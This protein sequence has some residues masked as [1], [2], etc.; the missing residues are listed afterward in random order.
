MMSGTILN[1]Q[2]RPCSGRITQHRQQPV[3]PVVASYSKQPAAVL[4]A[5]CPV[6]AP[7]RAA[8]LRHSLS[9][10]TRPR[11]RSGAAGFS[12]RA[13]QSYVMIKPDGVQ[14][15][16]V[17]RPSPLQRFLRPTR[18]RLGCCQRTVRRIC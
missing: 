6:H 5:S 18:C 15:G 14:R 17:R 16:L 10:A 11:S 13:E 4:H 12:V 9:R 7:F 1:Q 3:S 8:T 2:H